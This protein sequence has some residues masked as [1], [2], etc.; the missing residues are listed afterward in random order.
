MAAP[1]VLS[2]RIAFYAIY[3]IASLARARRPL[4]LSSPPSVVALIVPTPS[5]PRPPKTDA[6]P[7]DASCV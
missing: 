6:A 7:L 4:V 5:R 1:F 3:T 2:M